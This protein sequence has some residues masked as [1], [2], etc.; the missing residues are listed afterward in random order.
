VE[1]QFYLIAPI[2]FLIFERL[3]KVHISLKF[4]L[5]TLI[6]VASFTAQSLLNGDQAHVGLE[7]PIRLK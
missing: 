4:A 2:L 7:F 1:I 5:I 6:G 3:D